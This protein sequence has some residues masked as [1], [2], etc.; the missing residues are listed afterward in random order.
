MPGIPA[1][2]K[3]SKP[4][5]EFSN[6]PFT[7]GSRLW[8]WTNIGKGVS[9]LRTVVLLWNSATAWMGVFTQNVFVKIFLLCF[10][11]T[12]HIHSYASSQLRIVKSSYILFF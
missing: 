11:F 8:I 10:L 5:R 1:H 12:I 2:R 3:G 4:H 9:R 7:R 6:R